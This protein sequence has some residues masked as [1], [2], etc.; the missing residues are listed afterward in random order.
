MTHIIFGTFPVLLQCLFLVALQQLQQKKTLQNKTQTPRRNVAKPMHHLLADTYLGE[1]NNHIAN[2]QRNKQK[3][4]HLEPN[5]AP[6]DTNI[7][8]YTY[9]HT[10]THISIL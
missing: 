3:K 5:K 8:R 7:S 6:R 4:V 9:T 10:Q 1:E 2:S